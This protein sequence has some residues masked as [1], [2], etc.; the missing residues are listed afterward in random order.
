MSSVH[1]SSSQRARHG[2][3]TAFIALTTLAA[4]LGS[5]A[6]LAQNAQPQFV[7]IEFAVLR[8]PDG[9]PIGG[10]IDF[11]TL[12]PFTPNPNSLDGLLFENDVLLMR[13]TLRDPDWG[14]EIEIETDGETGDVTVTYT[15][16]EDPIFIRVF[17]N[18]IPLPGY[19]SPQPPPIPNTTLDFFD[20]EGFNWNSD[21]NAEPLNP[22]FTIV[23][24]Y[25]IPEW[26]GDNQARLRDIVM[27]DQRWNLV[28]DASND[29]DPE[30]ADFVRRNT[31]IY[32]RSNPLI[33]P[34]NPL[35]FADAGP[36]LTVGAD[37]TITLDGS[38][39]FDSFNLG[40]DIDNPNIFA[41]DRLRYAWEWISGP[42]RVDPVQTS[43]TSPFAS[44][45]LTT[46]SDADPNNL[47]PYVFRLSVS[48]EAN[49][50]P[51]TDIVRV[52]VLS[53]IV[54]PEP[55]VVII[56]GPLAP[57][58]VGEP[59]TISAVG[60]FSP[61][62]DPLT[63]RWVQTDELGNSLTEADVNRLF[64]PISGTNTA[65]ISWRTTATG[66]FFFRVLVSDGDLQSDEVF[67]L[68]VIDGSTA[69]LNDSSSDVDPGAAQD[70]D[71]ED[72][73]SVPTAMPCGAGLLPLAA[74]PF[75][76]LLLRRRD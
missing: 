65:T 32:G 24:A 19:D 38:D 18:W 27:W 61:Q 74:A 33:V 50:L 41:K 75:L 70:V 43:I 5:P 58:V 56:D 54:D 15:Y 13:L 21:L 25:P 3:S 8:T 52:T 35:P 16:N 47:V 2:L 72:P 40:F 55:P 12:P 51:T 63:Y 36:D 20:E 46:P 22:T 39:T 6:A 42:E 37:T 62:G 23:L 4:A 59:V 49:P 57:V 68:N 31:I 48:D 60:S 14:P 9:E 69:T 71:E 29:A 34:A 26:V 17:A 7:S 11:D 67:T 28:V 45:T 10:F 64:Q 76:L 30:P 66:T 53:Q 44:V 73:T 1:P